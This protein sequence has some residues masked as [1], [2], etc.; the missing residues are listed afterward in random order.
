L[1]PILANSFDQKPLR[2]IVSPQFYFLPSLLIGIAS[3][4]YLFGALRIVGI[5]GPY[6]HPGG[7]LAQH[8]AGAYAYLDGHWSF[9]LFY[10]DRINAPAGAN[11]IF[12]DSAP[13]A[14]LI[15]KIINSITGLRWNYIGT[16]FFVLWILQ[17][18]SG[19]FLARQLGVRGW[20]APTLIGLVALACPFFLARHGHLALSSH[21]LILFSLGFYFK[22]VKSQ[23]LSLY[24]WALILGVAIWTHAY[25]YLM[26]LAIFSATVSDIIITRRNAPFQTIALGIIIFTFTV[27]LALI[28]GYGGGSDLAGGYSAYSADLLSMV[29]PT[30]S[31][32]FNIKSPFTI[33][34]AVEGN[35]YLGLGGLFAVALAIF[36]PRNPPYYFLRQ[37]RALSIVLACLAIYAIGNIVRI[38]G[39]PIFEYHIPESLPPYSVLRSSG[40]MMWPLSYLILFLSLAIVAGR[41][42]SLPYKFLATVAL[43]F[44]TTVQVIDTRSL[45]DQIYQG[46]TGKDRVT[47]SQLINTVE[48]ISFL[49]PIDCLKFQQDIGPLTEA[50]WM[51]VK[52]GKQTDSAHLARHSEP[53]TCDLRR[54]SS[55][56]GTL[57]LAPVDLFKYADLPRDS[58]TQVDDLYACGEIVASNLSLPKLPKREPFRMSMTADQLMKSSKIG[59]LENGVLKNEGSGVVFYGPYVIAPAGKYRIDLDVDVS[60]ATSVIV[61]I[62]SESVRNK[63]FETDIAKSKSKSFQFNLN[64][65]V[66]DLEI[67][68]ISKDGAPISVRGY[69]I[70]QS[71]TEN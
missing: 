69:T 64:S 41:P 28:G 19:A 12:T 48:K 52:A 25:L 45:T 65:M 55:D 51:A 10:T 42:T 58:C 70:S 36:L 47:L 40:R 27:A 31:S 50:S 56:I 71:L 44:V 67:R 23:K 22:D 57:S 66:K 60:D 54:V 1:E 46:A 3:F 11:I 39:T 24:Y 5:G 9:P 37:H 26:C 21:F 16:W 34:V 17:P 18:V 53:L 15:A 32:I 49:I 20:I 63:H 14:A 38:A 43:I 4:L 30:G 33:A 2:I 6:D 7:D 62:V 35:N 61:D 59:Y 8:I 13:F 29:W 68:M